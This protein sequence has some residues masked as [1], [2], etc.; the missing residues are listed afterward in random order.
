MS[1]VSVIDPFPDAAQAAEPSATQV[2]Q[3]GLLD[4][5]QQREGEIFN[6]DIFFSVVELAIVFRPTPD[7]LGVF[8]VDRGRAD[9]DSP[10]GDP[11][12]ER[13]LFPASTM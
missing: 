8:I 10:L 7:T 6:N 9:R 4:F 1:A 13:E 11:A 5:F 3:L 2:Q 12:I